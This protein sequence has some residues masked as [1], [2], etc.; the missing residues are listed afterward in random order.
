MS[1]SPPYASE[2]PALSAPNVVPEAFKNVW[3]E[4]MEA[5]GSQMKTAVEGVAKMLSI[6]LGLGEDTLLE[7]GKYG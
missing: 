7:A 3:K 2:F 4:K 6:G 1:Q 5:W